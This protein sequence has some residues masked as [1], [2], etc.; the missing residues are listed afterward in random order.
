L[1]VFSFGAGARAL[2]T[3]PLADLSVAL[4]L[5]LHAARVSFDGHAEAPWTAESGGRWVAAPYAGATAAYRLH[6]R[7]ALRLDL[8]AS[9][10]RPEPVLRIAGR[11]VA[12][13][14]QPAVF[15]SLSV[16]VRP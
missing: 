11:E 14:G 16:E 12:S 10:V 13:F 4:G 7:V 5:G 9:L 15:P 1:K 8:L 6:P 3:D 2:L